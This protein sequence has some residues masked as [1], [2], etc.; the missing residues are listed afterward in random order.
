MWKEMLFSVPSVL[1]GWLKV[2][3]QASERRYHTAHSHEKRHRNQQPPSATIRGPW[4]Q[5][6]AH[7]AMCQT[8]SLSFHMAVLPN[9]LKAPCRLQLNNPSKFPYGISSLQER[10]TKFNWLAWS[11]W[12]D[13]NASLGLTQDSIS[14]PSDLPAHCNRSNGEFKCLPKPS[15]WIFPALCLLFLHHGHSFINM[16]HITSMASVFFSLS[17]YYI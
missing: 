11:M 3:L 7:T 16:K 17:L 14:A 5:R 8:P 1:G 6:C 12:Q 15:R 4:Q 2:A 9:D 13:R 10:G